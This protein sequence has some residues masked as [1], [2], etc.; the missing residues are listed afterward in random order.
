MPGARRSSLSSPMR[1]KSADDRRPQI[2]QLTTLLSRPDVSE[3]TRQRIELEIR[4]IKAGAQGEADAAYQI[5]FHYGRDPD[6]MTLHDLRIACDG[7][8][9]QIDHLIITRRFEFWVCESK[10]FSEGVEINEQGEWSAYRSGQKR[11]IPS[12]IEQ[13]R[14]HI[15]VLTDVFAKRLVTMPT[16]VGLKFRATLRSLVLV[17]DRTQITRPSGSTSRPVD[18]LGSVIKADQLKTTID[19]F[20]TQSSDGNNPATIVSAATIESVARQLAALHA[21]TRHVW[22]KRF[23]LP[24]Q[25]SRTPGTSQPRSG[26]LGR[27]VF[28]GLSGTRTSHA[29]GR[30]YCESCGDTVSDAVIEYCRQYAALLEGSVLC[31]LCQDEFYPDR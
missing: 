4:T 19:R 3:A 5:E 11:G 25:P 7:R 16:R 6:V 17:S 22:S 21:P 2:A 29:R 30:S 8:V 9:A 14:R 20:S 31:V 23:G 18:G 1:I 28:P 10:R 15:A 26:G 13:N 27:V 12:P 24:E